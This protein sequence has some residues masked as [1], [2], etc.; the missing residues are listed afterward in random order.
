MLFVSIFAYH[1]Y[2][3]L[4]VNQIPKAPKCKKVE[5]AIFVRETVDNYILAANRNGY[6]TEEL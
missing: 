6:L 2:S 5:N 4:R 1:S 3:Y